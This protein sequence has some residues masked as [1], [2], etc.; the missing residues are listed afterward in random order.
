M[1]AS[2]AV[3]ISFPGNARE[4][5]THYH[6]V[7][8]GD[9]QVIG[10]GDIPMPDMPFDPGPDDVAHAFLQAPGGFI[11]GADAIPEEWDKPL[12]DT[13]YSLLYSLDTPEEARRVIDAF[14]AGGGERNMPFE[15]A[16]WGDWYGQVFD[17]FGVMWALSVPAADSP[18][19]E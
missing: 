3:Y 15:L 8:G 7:L 14:L 18:T 9:L 6:E 11:A 4:A 12:R 13:A 2:L 1:S 10:Y 16:P 17:R 19:A 5:F